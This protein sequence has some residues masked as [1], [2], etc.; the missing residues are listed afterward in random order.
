MSP[1]N[2]LLRRLDDAGVTVLTLDDPSSRNSLSEAM[3]SALAAELAS[4]ERDEQVRCLV[5]AA[6]GPVFSSGHHLKE[7]QAHRADEDGGTG[8]LADLLGRC[9]GVMESLPRL[10]VPV[11]A[12]V[13]GFATAAGCQLVAS[14]DLVV[15]GSAA[16]FCTPGVNLGMFCSTPAVAVSRTI[17]PKH[18]MEM[19]LTAGV[20]DAATAARFGLVNHVVPENQAL[21]EA[22][23]LAR[24]IADRSAEA[25]AFGKPAFYEQLA[26]PLDEAYAL[27]SQVM[28]RNFVADEAKLGIGAFLE[29]RD[30]QWR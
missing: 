1:P 25:I 26:Q 15:A 14:C 8:Y 12:A 19:L 30:V 11:I 24:R 22:F 4:V 27:A 7:M 6:E 3:L 18:A 16:R 28:V 13:E 20:F 29:K 10:R 5:L 21:P 17:A 23:S 2:T 9:A